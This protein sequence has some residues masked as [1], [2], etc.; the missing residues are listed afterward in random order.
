MLLRC[1]L[2]AA[3]LFLAPAAQA[4]VKAVAS[5]SILGDIVKNVGGDRVAVMTL[6]GPDGDAH[7]FQPTPGDAKALAGAQIVFLNG[8]GFEGWMERLTQSAG[9]KGPVV[10]AS[11]GVQAQKMAADDDHKGHAHGHSHAKKDR[12]D[13]HDHGALDPHAWQ[14]PRNVARYVDNIAAGLAKA[15]PA[16]EAQYRANADAYKKQLAE[17]DSWAKG[18]LAQVPK[19]KRKVIT[20]HDAF[21]YFASAYGVAFLAPVG[22]ST[23]AEPSAKQVAGLIRQIRKEKTTAL[24]VENITNPKLIEQ[25]GKETGVKPGGRLYSDAL[26]KPGAG[27]DTYLAMLR[28]N[29]AVLKAAMIGS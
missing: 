7:V 20:S 5:F 26:S 4:Q 8:L 11:Q 22:I 13:A 23:D 18:E 21:G 14:D 27:G 3:A 17:L 2:L 6:V 12:K 1:I 24:F 9:Y 10:V 16:G 15:D 29:V 28:H 19:Q 25:I